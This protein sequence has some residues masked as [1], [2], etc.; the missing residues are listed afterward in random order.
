MNLYELHVPWEWRCIAMISYID[1]YVI[2]RKYTSQSSMYLQYSYSTEDCSAVMSPAVGCADDCWRVLQ[3]SPHSPAPAA[4]HTQPTKPNSSGS[5]PSLNQLSPWLVAPDT[6]ATTETTTKSVKLE[7]PVIH[8]KTVIT[9]ELWWCAE[10]IPHRNLLSNWVNYVLQ[11][12]PS[13]CENVG[14]WYIYIGVPCQ[15]RRLENSPLL[16]G[17]IR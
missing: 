17:E 1:H 12:V 10:V 6:S 9:T 7:Q 14:R 15:L 5:M 11:G 2:V 4:V 16:A 13:K 3:E 8:R